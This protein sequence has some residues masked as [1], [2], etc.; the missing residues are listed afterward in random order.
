MIGD[1]GYTGKVVAGLLAV[2]DCHGG[3]IRKNNERGKNWE[4]DRWLTGLRMPY[5]GVFALMPMIFETSRQA[6]FLIP[7]AIS[8]G[9]G[10]L[11][12]TFITLFLVPALYLITE[13][14]KHIWDG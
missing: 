14:F 7:M 13:D 10:I 9:Y 1:K 4:K 5:E 8:L 2:R 3:I 12:A 11:F 6:K